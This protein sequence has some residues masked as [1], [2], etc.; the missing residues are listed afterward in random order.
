MLKI[1]DSEIDEIKALVKLPPLVKSTID[2][3]LHVL[4]NKTVKQQKEAWK[5]VKNHKLDLLKSAKASKLSDLDF[6]DCQKIQTALAEIDAD[7]LSAS[8]AALASIHSWVDNSVQLRIAAELYPE[9]CKVTAEAPVKPKTSA[10]PKTAK[11]N[12]EQKDGGENGVANGAEKK[13]GKER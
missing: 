11:V 13:K 2:V 9:E 3:F 4:G 1:K 8:S 7:K 6:A 12:G 5:Q 10:R